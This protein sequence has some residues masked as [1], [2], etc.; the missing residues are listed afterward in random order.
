MVDVLGAL[1][2]D[3]ALRATSGPQG[4]AVVIAAIVTLVGRDMLR[5]ADRLPLRPAIDVAVLALTL[6]A[7]GIVGVRLTA[8]AT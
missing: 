3:D 6:A 5:A 7:F 8:L 1:T 2:L 4:Y